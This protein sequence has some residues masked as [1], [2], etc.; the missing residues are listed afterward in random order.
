MLKGAVHVSTPIWLGWHLC[1]VGAG[2]GPWAK[3][4]K[5]CGDVGSPATHTPIYPPIG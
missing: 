4:P 3:G 5:G 2:I 1:Y